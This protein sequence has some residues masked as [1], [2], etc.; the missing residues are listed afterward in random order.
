MTIRV[1]QENS[2]GQDSK[3]DNATEC[4]G[5]EIRDAL[6][7]FLAEEGW[8]F[9]SLCIVPPGYCDDYTLTNTEGESIYSTKYSKNLQ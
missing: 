6:L 8:L 4:S 9:A 1:F 5:K 7:R 2:H 3:E